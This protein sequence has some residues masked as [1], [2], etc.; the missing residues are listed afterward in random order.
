MTLF[1]KLAIERSQM[2][3]MTG[4]TNFALIDKE[5]SKKNVKRTKD[6]NSVETNETFW[7]TESI[8]TEN[9]VNF[10]NLRNGSIICAKKNYSNSLIHLR[11][12]ESKD[13]NNKTNC[14]NY[15]KFSLCK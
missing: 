15:C 13:E 9:D 12:D 6:L 2:L 10:H 7:P 3:S 8:R 4:M 5:E 1:L 11:P 14:I